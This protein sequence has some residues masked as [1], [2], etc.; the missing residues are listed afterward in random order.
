MVLRDSTSPA[1]ELFP[2]LC[3]GF[4]SMHMKDGGDLQGGDLRRRSKELHL[5]ERIFVPCEC[6]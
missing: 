6:K 2:W 5:K 1:C 4:P 3:D